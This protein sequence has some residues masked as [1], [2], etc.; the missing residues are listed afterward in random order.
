M[1][2]QTID[3]D[4][5]EFRVAWNLLRTTRRS[6]FLTGKA[7][8]GKSTFLKYI[9]RNTD[10]KYVVLAPTGIAAVN[11][12]GVTMHSFFRLPFKP[13]LPDDPEFSEHRLKERMKY[14]KPLIKLIRELD[15]I[16]IDEISMV[17]ADII[18][19]IDKILRV[20]C[21]NRR[22]PFGGKQLLLVGDV[23][24]LEPVVTG[25]MRDILARFYPDNYFYSARVFQEVK[26][27]PIELRKVYRQSD[28]RF[29]DLLDRM[30]SGR[31][32]RADMELLNAKVGREMSAG[33]DRMVMTL[34]TTRGTVD[35]INDSK[36]EELPSEEEL[37]IGEITGDFPE[38]A[39]P[40][41]LE[42]TLKVGAQVVFIKNDP[43]RRWVNG[44]IG[45][46]ISID[47]DHIM[48]ELD[49]GDTH[50]VEPAVWSNIRYEYDEAS[51]KV[52]EIVLGQ[53]KQF[54]VRLAWALTIHKS[55]GLTFNNVIIDMGSGAF[56]GGQAYV[57]LSRCRSLEGMAMRSTINERDVFVNPSV[58][59]FSNGFND[60]ALVN[61]AIADER[62]RDTLRHCLRAV[63]EGRLSDAWAMYYGLMAEFPQAAA[64]MTPQLSRLV[65]RR[66]YSAERYRREVDML[67]R[68]IDDDN[69][70]FRKLAMEYV[71][72]ASEC[73]K[74][75]MELTPIIANYDKAIAISPDCVEAWIGR[76]KAL[77]S[78]DDTDGALAA[79]GEAERLLSAA[80]VGDV[81]LRVTV[82]LDR[83]KL[84]YRAGDMAGALD[85]LLQA[86]E[87]DVDNPKVHSLLAQLYE[88]TGDERN[89]ARHRD[90]ERRNR[91]RRKS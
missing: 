17:R 47:D 88:K 81:K 2:Q 91:R 20:Y 72:M 42:L 22:E 57:A 44:T 29:I 39:L 80:G 66:L 25:D 31:P 19:F 5:P 70:R 46:V 75:G 60:M 78:V 87:L 65:R 21:D 40:T 49:S 24:Q 18:D 10:K 3:L 63:D 38:N 68:H 8:T 69:A 77:A 50:V 6:V 73:L 37:L 14:P 23:F 53:F 54:P 13:L 15:L 41:L 62:M 59:R 84:L 64:M 34:A 56:S 26:L 58:V 76:G 90:L 79:Y 43:E 28:S 89:A 67:R 7:G 12:G 16:I 35:S 11:A 86:E 83:G 4:N 48:V 9:C 55:Q 32:T 51:R 1:S 82:A 71:A 74:E 30:R 36:L 27:V 52:K 33:D 85:S 61:E 45:R